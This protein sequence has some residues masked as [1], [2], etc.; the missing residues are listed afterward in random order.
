MFIDLANVKVKT[1][2]KEQEDE[3]E[4]GRQKCTLKRKSENVSSSHAHW[5]GICRPHPNVDLTFKL[6]TYNNTHRFRGHDFDCFYRCGLQLCLLT[7]V[8]NIHTRRLYLVLTTAA[9]VASSL[10]IG[11]A[12][13]YNTSPQ[14]KPQDS[15]PPQV[16]VDPQ[17]RQPAVYDE[18][19]DSEE[20]V[21]DGDLSA[22]RA[23]VLEPCKLV[24]WT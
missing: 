4:D 1:Q 10:A 23:G 14:A 16:S 6:T 18:D 20:E 2:E 8:T 11:Y 12:V 7:Y 5:I 13:G 22:V 15:Q 21:A 3:D 19:G 9:L 24:R 17:P